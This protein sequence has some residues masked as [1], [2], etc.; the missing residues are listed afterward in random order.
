[1]RVRFWS[2]THEQRRRARSA[3]FTVATLVTASLGAHAQVVTC[4]AEIRSASVRDLCLTV[5]PTLQDG[6][7]AQ[8]AFCPFGGG[9]ASNGGITLWEIHLAREGGLWISPV[10]RTDRRLEVEGW[11]GDNGAAVQLWGANV[12]HWD[13][14]QTWTLFPDQF[15]R[16]VLI[17]QESTKCLDSPGGVRN[18]AAL[19]QFDCHGADNQRWWINPVVGSCGNLLI[20]R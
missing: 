19:Q 4:G 5:A 15:G 18:G 9:P 12:P 10:T 14:N 7:R 20:R 6:A 16:S 2:Q 8:L 11:S 13:L 17:N 3:V 1:M